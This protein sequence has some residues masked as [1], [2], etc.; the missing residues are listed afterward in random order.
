LPVIVAI[1][2]L[3]A[4]V[5]AQSANATPSR[6][7]ILTPSSGQIVAGKTVVVRVR[8]LSGH[9]TA[10]VGNRSVRARFGPSR[11]GVRTAVLRR[12]RDF[13]AG[14]QRL[15]IGLT[16][17]R[18]SRYAARSFFASS[19]ASLLRLTPVHNASP[20]APLQMLL[21]SSASIGELRITLNGRRL[22]Q[23]YAQRTAH[24]YD[25]ILGASDGLHY[26]RNRLVVS[27]LASGG[28]RFDRAVRIVRIPKSRPLPGAG[29]D[30][31]TV[32]G[33]SVELDGS[34]TRA[35]RGARL[36][37]RWQIFQRPRG[38]KAKI[39][40]AQ[41]KRAALMPDKPGLYR[42][43][44]IVEPHGASSRAHA[45]A[46]APASDEMDVEVKRSTSPLGLPIQTI[47]AGGNVELGNEILSAEPGA[48]VQ[49]VVLDRTTLAVKSQQSIAAPL[50]VERNV[51]KD[52]ESTLLDN[53]GNLVIVSGGGRSTFLPGT[54]GYDPLFGLATA[55]TVLGAD[56]EA[57]T[58]GGGIVES[59]IE[60]GHWSVVGV[61]G[62]AAGSATQNFRGVV[63]GGVNSGSP[64][65]APGSLQGYLEEG[66][67]GN[68]AFVDAEHAQIDTYAAAASEQVSSVT[69]GEHTYTTEPIPAGASGFHVL[70]FDSQLNVLRNNVYITNSP[71][72]GTGESET[73]SLVNDLQQIANNPE[74]AELVI[75]QS[76]GHP[77]GR[78]GYWVEDVG[79]PAYPWT[80][81]EN[82]VK[83]RPVPN[84]LSAWTNSAQGA[85]LAS[86]IG[87]LGGASAHDQVAQM[88][89]GTPTPQPSYAGGGY[90]LVAEPGDPEAAI[91]QSQVGSD[92][93]APR[94]T[95]TLTRTQSTSWSVGNATSLEDF[96]GEEASPLT[97][98]YQPPTPWPDSST[99]GDRAAERY[100]AEQLGLN[101]GTD[102]VQSVREAYY[103]EDTDSWGN[104]ASE[105]T[106][107]VHFRS[108]L[109]FSKTEFSALKAQ[110]LIEMP[111]VAN[112]EKLIKNWQAMF[113]NNK[114][115]S[116]IDLQT[117]ANTIEGQIENDIAARKASL[118]TTNILAHSLGIA[119]GLLSV[120]GV[121]VVGG[122]IGA[123]ANALLLSQDL[124]QEANGSLSA[125]PI[126]TE[127]DNLGQQLSTRYEQIQANLSH[128]G[129]LLVSDWG[130]LQ[131]A[132]L[133]ANAAW[134][135]NS[136]VREYLE[137]TLTKSAQQEAYR[138]L[139]PL[140]Y[141][142]YLIAPV[143]T[144]YNHEPSS[145]PWNYTCE[146]SS[147]F[148]P[149]GI[150]PFSATQSESEA[151]DLFGYGATGNSQE[152]FH[153]RLQARVLSTQA[154]LGLQEQGGN[155]VMIEDSPNVLPTSKLSPSLFKP[156][157]SDEV[158]KSVSEKGG[159]EKGNL[160]MDRI[161]L[162]GEAS[163]PRWPLYCQHY[164]DG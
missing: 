74:A 147:A 46:V 97:I 62:S 5:G 159:L 162:M 125:R 6:L 34:D 75:V 60:Q 4:S 120:A 121:P 25:L 153:S 66:S 24:S 111:K 152:G 59:A 90:T 20:R 19:R 83:A 22:S 81:P 14:P 119:A 132:A 99:A 134:A 133:D 76:I 100:I 79:I 110:L 78:S 140:A 35:R 127:A 38:S 18:A 84:E 44:L 41:S 136:S 29:A 157:Q 3:A 43:H 124:A 160:Q 68:F 96:G 45:A 10:F 131:S 48:W 28:K 163:F 89:G 161:Q 92:L 145:G 118:N 128:L 106:T 27:L 138:S 33:R 8:G 36:T 116:Y 148:D 2:G 112:V 135:L 12:G 95:G 113:T 139:L 42:M 129:D 143:A 117:I 80:E 61:P 156:F 32:V 137:G 108:G 123:L 47:G 87:Q 9:F 154:E 164:P 69:V 98:A 109:G 72:S 86:D 105:L 7:A 63:T 13:D 39:R 91:S 85:S 51:L 104:V 101:R 11:N 151:W 88:L 77:S 102:A 67:L 144:D 142:E 107:T 15:A 122:G 82:S 54:N 71:G 37:Y 30:R 114:T 16:S 126:V 115:T 93:Q 158:E 1:A 50:G 146:N 130:K 57:I 26:G 150:Q 55:L 73:A 64:V 40:S 31:R 49:V 56:P 103:V 70:T 149:K 53:V 17:S 58:Q 94:V 52:L 65:G 23:S 141:G 155:H 21:R